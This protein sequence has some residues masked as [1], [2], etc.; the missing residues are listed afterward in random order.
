MDLLQLEHFQYQCLTQNHNKLP[1]HSSSLSLF[2][3]S[4]KTLSIR[5]TIY[6]WNDRD[7]NALVN[8]PDHFTSNEYLPFIS[9]DENYHSQYLDLTKTPVEN[10][11]LITF[12]QMSIQRASPLLTPKQP[13]TSISHI[14]P[15]S[16]IYTPLL[17]Q[18][19]FSHIRLTQ[20]SH[21]HQFQ[22]KL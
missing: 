19:L 1:K 8:V 21:K 13:H 7:Q 20:T 4:L 9:V 18:S 16:S 2:F 22:T 17:I 14:T 3:V 5:L 10:M 12:N 15:I 6:M 11:K